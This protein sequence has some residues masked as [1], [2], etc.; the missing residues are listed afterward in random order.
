MKST[1]KLLSAIALG[2]AM[3]LPVYAQTPATKP[4]PPPLKPQAGR[5][6]KDVV[7]D[8]PSFTAVF[9]EAGGRLKSFQLKQYK[10]RMPLKPVYHF[11]LGP[12]AFEVER[13]LPPAAAGGTQEVHSWVL[14]NWAARWS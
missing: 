1:G 4:A 5:P 3:T 6:A 10:D 7:V 9:T 14:G 12:V 11:K 13:Y 8:T 2:A